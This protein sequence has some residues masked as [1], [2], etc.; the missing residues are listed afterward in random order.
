MNAADENAKVGGRRAPR[1]GK[2]IE[3]SQTGKLADYA[4]ALEER[5]SA[6]QRLG[7]LLLAQEQHPQNAA[8]EAQI[9]AISC[10][11]PPSASLSSAGEDPPSSRLTQIAAGST[12]CAIDC[13][14]F[15]LKIAHEDLRKI[16]EP[17][18][19]IKIMRE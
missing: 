7:G 1:K 15:D 6:R 16:F 8:N 14:S 18:N 11:F 13:A 12:A 4:Q 2:A 5:K 10:C 9:A 17:A 19:A 3:A